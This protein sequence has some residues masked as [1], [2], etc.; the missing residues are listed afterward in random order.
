M[1]VSRMHHGRTLDTVKVPAK[2]KKWRESLIQLTGEHVIDRLTHCCPKILQARLLNQAEPL[3]MRGAG[4][5]GNMNHADIQ[6]IDKTYQIR[7][8]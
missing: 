1:T 7:N 6:L 8:F 3:K 2:T 5:T 4:N